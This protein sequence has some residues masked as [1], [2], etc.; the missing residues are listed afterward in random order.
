MNVIENK[1]TKINF[2]KKMLLLPCALLVMSD[3]ANATSSTDYELKNVL[4]V[5]RHGLRAPLIDGATQLIDATPNKW[6]EWDT[7]AGLLTTK[8]GVLEVYMGH[9]FTN[10]LNQ[11]NL[12]KKDNC[13]TQSELYVYSNVMSRTIATAQFFINGA[14]PGCEVKINHLSD[15]TAKDPLFFQ[16]VKDNSK[17]FNLAGTKEIE[18]FINSL[19]LKPSYQK[20]EHVLDYKNSV[21]CKVNKNC[22]LSKDKNTVELVYGKEPAIRGVLHKSFLAIDAFMLQDYEG[23][24]KNQVAWGNIKTHDDWVSLAKLRNSYIE[25]AYLQ[26]II[27]KNIIN[28]MLKNIDKILKDKNTKVTLIVGHDTTVGPILTAMQFNEYVLSEQFEK[29][30]IGGKI[31]FQRWFDKKANRDLLKVEYVYQS[32][33][34]M[35][36]LEPL[37]L[38]N[39]P[40]RVTLTLKGCEADKNGFCPWSNFEKA[41]VKIL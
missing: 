12:L 35:R 36:D 21:D 26:P 28:P 23:F 39:P 6:P 24:P 32:T 14:Y 4:I 10:W 30:P 8:G 22:D 7:K 5:S 2:I 17:E 20:L 16:S 25:A 15:L 33:Q 37:T 13:P 19:N 18:T 11:Q 9:Y 34:Q 31:V 41:M 38:N 1:I 40:M 29:T 27:V 3:I